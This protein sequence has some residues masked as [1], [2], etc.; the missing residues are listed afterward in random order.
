MV[1][2]AVND[3]YYEEVVVK[4]QIKNNEDPSYTDLIKTKIK[5]QNDN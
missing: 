5:N 2:K 1:D 4:R 3:Y